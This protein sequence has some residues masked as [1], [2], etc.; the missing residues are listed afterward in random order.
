MQIVFYWIIANV[1]KE[2]MLV[3]TITSQYSI[4]H[5]KLEIW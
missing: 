4:F 3:S 2:E 1:H 5:K